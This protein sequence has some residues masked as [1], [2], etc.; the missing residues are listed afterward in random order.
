MGLGFLI[1]RE[2]PMDNSRTMKGNY[3]E[4]GQ[5]E[6]INALIN[7]SRQRGGVTFEIFSVP[8]VDKR[9]DEIGTISFF[10]SF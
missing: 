10:K 8:D 5:L 2:Q 3:Y 9:K 6:V 7:E 4:W 1:L